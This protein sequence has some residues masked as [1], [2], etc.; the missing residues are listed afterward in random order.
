M[1]NY[2]INKFG[3]P[4]F[5]N[6]YYAKLFGKKAKICT[7]NKVQEHFAKKELNSYSASENKF[8]G[9]E[10]LDDFFVP[11]LLADTIDE[12]FEAMANTIV[13]KPLQIINQKVLKT[14]I[15]DMF[16]ISG[17]WLIEHAV[18]HTDEKPWL[19]IVA[20]EQA[21]P[22]ASY[23]AIPTSDW[24]IFDVETFVQ[25]SRDN[26]P[27][28][29]TAIGSENGQ[30]CYYLWTHEALLNPDIPYEPALVPIGKGKV[31]IAHNAS[32][33]AAKVQERYT[34]EPLNNWY[35]CTQ[36]MH[37][38]SNG[39]SSDQ[40][41]AINKKPTDGGCSFLKYGSG[42]SLVRAYEFHTGKKLPD[43]AK[44]P[45]ALFVQA[46]HISQIFARLS[47][48]LEYAMHDP[49]LTL[50]LFQKVWPK[51]RK[52]APSKVVLAGHMLLLNSILPVIPD[53]YDWTRRVEKAYQDANAEI[54]TLL[55]E[56]ADIVHKNWQE[57]PALI[58]SDH[59][60]QH[61][62]WR[63]CSKNEDSPLYNIAK[64]YEGKGVH[65][66]LL[67]ISGK[68]DDAHW[69]LQLCWNGKPLTKTKELGWHFIN[70]NGKPERVPHSTGTDTNVGSLLNNT[71][72]AALEDGRLT[73]NA[74]SCI[75]GLTEKATRIAKLIRLSSYWSGMRNRVLEINAEPYENPID[76]SRM[77]LLAP[78]V[79]PAGTSSGRIT[80][81]IWAV[82]AAHVYPKYGK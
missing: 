80:D 79:N 16:H 34:L 37:A 12:H 68:S 59:W 30:L 15:A 81:N 60:L 82:L 55:N 31:I 1:S 26:K 2:R 38:T 53:W 46:T 75:Q 13:Q 10:M 50:E 51:Y 4:V 67:D 66:H 36:A 47:D 32:F 42:N 73:T 8:V 44:D 19:R 5:N 9:N 58:E 40:R 11:P 20:D 17:E 52:T 24:L 7:L 76:G 62:D 33:D 74:N 61:L 27:I 71:Y 21:K 64:W 78:R 43:D 23:C 18:P 57:N 65:G 28:I 63:R 25:G 35:I 14:D 6:A 45:R 54:R 39:L 77:M 29:G 22:V 48:A 56:I 70:E 3:Y 49:E 69:L 72:I 41:W